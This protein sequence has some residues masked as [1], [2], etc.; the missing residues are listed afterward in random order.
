MSAQQEDAL[1]NKYAWLVP[2]ATWGRLHYIPGVTHETWRT[3]WDDY[4]NEG[5]ERTAICGRTFVV[6]LP[7][8]FSRMGLDRCA[9]CCDRLGITRGHG[10]CPNDDT[11]TA[12]PDSVKETQQP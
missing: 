11:A 5:H 2:A 7:G 4:P 10:A 12:I 8:I 6:T 3:W 9:H 1:T